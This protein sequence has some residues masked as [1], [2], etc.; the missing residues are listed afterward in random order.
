MRGHIFHRQNHQRNAFSASKRPGMTCRK[1]TIDRI[2][3]ISNSDVDHARLKATTAH[4]SGEW[5]HAPHIALIGLK[6]TDEEIQI[7]VAQRLGVWTCLPHTCICGKLVDVRGLHGFSCR[8][9]TQR[10]KRH[11]L[12]KHIIWRA[13]KRGQIPAHKEPIGLITYGG[14]RPAGATLIPWSK[15]KPLAWDVTVHDTFADSHIN[16]TPS[17]AGAAARQAA[18]T[19]NTKY[20]DI[21]S[22]HIFYLIAIE[23]IGSW[24]VQALE[25]IEEIGRRVT[26][27]MEDPKETMYLFQRLSR[28][29]RGVTRCH[30][31]TPLTK[32]TSRNP[33]QS[34]IFP[35]SNNC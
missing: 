19:K 29:F 7:S 24:D 16:M 4:H 5:L 9:S 32:T 35:L 6:L 12:L 3:L 11:A 2:A 31:S 33:S 17:E 34:T 22:T 25:V 21:T 20:I 28:P 26:E 14:K 10:H 13:I 23:T 27:A 30:S 1:V 8:K 18:S 15:G